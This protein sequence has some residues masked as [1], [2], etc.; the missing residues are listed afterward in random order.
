MLAP[1]PLARFLTAVALMT[2]PG[3]TV[4]VASGYAALGNRGGI[5]IEVSIAIY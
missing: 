4:T 5:P 1:E 3:S 2:L